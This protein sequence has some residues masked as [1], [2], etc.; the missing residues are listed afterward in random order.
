MQSFEE[1]AKIVEYHDNV[2]LIQVIKSLFEQHALAGKKALLVG[3]AAEDVPLLKA[4]FGEGVFSEG[5]LWSTEQAEWKRVELASLGPDGCPL[6][7]ADVKRLQVAFKL[8]I[9]KMAPD[10]YTSDDIRYGSPKDFNWKNDAD[11]MYGYRPDPIPV[12]SLIVVRAE[13][14]GAK[15]WDLLNTFSKEFFQVSRSS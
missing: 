9:S 14:M 6:G 11:R 13:C 10:D 8:D 5:D 4:E 12:D 2:H 3:G 15:S 1:E 7:L